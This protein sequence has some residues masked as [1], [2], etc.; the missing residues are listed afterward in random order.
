DVGRRELRVDGQ[1]VDLTP[2][3][4]DLLRILM[5]APG[6]VFTRDELLE[7]GLGYAYQGMGRTLDSHIRN[8]RRKIEANP[9]QPTCIQTVYG[10]GYRLADEAL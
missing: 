8:L 9:R 10:V 7:K 3:E 5:Q 2:T 4:F 1:A 6:Y